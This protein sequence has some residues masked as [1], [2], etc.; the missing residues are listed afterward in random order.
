MDHLVPVVATY[1]PPLSHLL[2]TNIDHFDNP[3]QFLDPNACRTTSGFLNF[4]GALT[5]AQMKIESESAAPVIR[6]KNIEDTVNQGLEQWFRWLYNA[7][8]RGEWSPSRIFVNS[9][10]PEEYAYRYERET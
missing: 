5:V 4:L 9:R 1:R 2:L 10:N 3:E 7:M 8:D 6:F